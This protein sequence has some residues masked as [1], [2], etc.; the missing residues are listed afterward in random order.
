MKQPNHAQIWIL[1]LPPLQI[2]KSYII[3][4]RS[5][6]ASGEFC[7][8]LITKMSAIASLDMWLSKKLIT[9]ARM[10]MLVC[11]FVVLTPP[12]PPWQA[13]SRRCH[14]CVWTVISLWILCVLH[15]LFWACA[16]YIFYVAKSH[17]PRR[18]NT[19]LLG[20]QQ[21]YK[22]WLEKCNFVCSRFRYVTF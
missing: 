10:H 21:S 6:L 19:C 12:P 5:F 14:F 2:A 4:R 18:D 13:F 8:L 20:F 15:R 11:A 1:K 22:D 7:C 3:F 9:K 17:S 16:T